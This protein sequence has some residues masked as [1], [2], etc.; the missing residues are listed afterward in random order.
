MRKALADIGYVQ[1]ASKAIKDL[2]IPAYV[3]SFHSVNSK[4]HQADRKVPS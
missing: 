2:L 4:S 3:T 1:T